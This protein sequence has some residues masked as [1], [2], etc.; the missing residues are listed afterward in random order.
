M[1]MMHRDAEIG[2]MVQLS[3]HIKQVGGLAEVCTIMWS[4]FLLDSVTNDVDL[5]NNHFTTPGEPKE[6][7]LLYNLL[8]EQPLNF[9]DPGVLT[10]TDSTYSVKALQENSV[11][12]LS[13]CFKTWYQHPISNQQCESIER[14]T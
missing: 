2:Q 14:M 6:R 8:L 11:V 9:Y 13:F 12:W 5:T 1:Q 10:A 7:L 4:R 3:F